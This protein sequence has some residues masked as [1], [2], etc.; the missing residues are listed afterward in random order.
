MRKRGSIHEAIGGEGVCGRG[1]SILKRG[2][3]GFRICWDEGLG[4]GFLMGL[5]EESGLLG[6]KRMNMDIMWGIFVRWG[7]KK[8]SMMR[9]SRGDTVSYREAPFSC[10]AEGKAPWG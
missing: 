4:G 2:C 3:C 10:A 7:K 8:N 1:R 9:D 5:G 6:G